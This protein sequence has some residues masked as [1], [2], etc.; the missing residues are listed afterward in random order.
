VKNFVQ[1]KNIL[2]G[3]A[4]V[5]MFMLPAMAQDQQLETVTVTGIR[6]SLASAQAI[7][8]NSDQVVDS[9]TAVDIGA[10]PDR[11]VA[12]ALQ[13]VPG[14]TLVRGDTPNDL[15]RMGSTGNNVFVR[16][17][18]WVQ[19]T[20]NGRNEFSAID[21]RTLAF[22][23][24]SA[25]LLSGVD[26]FKSPTAK[27]I[28]GG[29]GGVID[30]KTRKP[31]DQDGRKFAISGDYTYGDMVDRALPSG[32]ALYS[33]RFNTRIGEIGVLASI[34][35]Q[36]QMSRTSG[37]NLN[38]FDCWTS[39]GTK[40]Q[41]TATDSTYS[42]CVSASDS[43][44]APSGFAWRQ[45]DYRQQRLAANV[46]LQWRP[47]EKL[48]FTLSG[49][50]TFANFNDVEHY[51]YM[52]TSSYATYIA[53][54]NYDS[55]NNWT[56]GSGKLSGI[57]TR[58]GAGHNRTSDISINAKWTP[59][60]NLEISFDS[61]FVESDRQY[62]NNTFATGVRNAQEISLDISDKNSPKISYTDAS[63]S[64]SDPDNYY[65]Y[66]AMDHM[67]YN[68]AH[69]FANRVDAS[70]KFNGEGL[71]G[72]IKSVEVG[73]RAENKYSVQ[74]ATGYNWASI[75][76]MGWGA[77]GVTLAGNF[78][79]SSYTA[80]DGTTVS[81]TS[82]SDN[83]KKLNSYGEL[84]HYNNVF[85]S[86][87]PALYVP[88]KSLVLMNTYAATELTHSLNV[89][90][91]GWNSYT[92]DVGCKSQQVTCLA[93]YENTT[94]GSNVSGN[95]IS[96]QTQDSYAGYA[97]VNF[98]KSTFFGWDIPIDGNFGVRVVQ[99]Q[100]VT[101]TGKVVMPSAPNVA[102]AYSGNDGCTKALGQEMSAGDAT[103]IITNCDD[104]AKAVAFWGDYSN[105]SYSTPRDPVSNHYWNVLPSF[106]LRA[107]L[108][109]TVQARLGYS[110]TMLRPEFKYTA[111]DA[112]Y[113]FNWGGSSTAKAFSFEST[114]SGY[115]YN[116]LLKPMHSTNL[117]A[118]VE[119]YFSQ[120]GSLTASVFGK[121]ISNYIYTQTATESVL[122]P[123]GASMDF[124]NT[125]YVNGTK[126]GVDGW[127]LAYQ[128]FYDFLPG[129]W[130]GFGFQA[131]YTKIFN[132][133]GHNNSGYIGASDAVAS[134]N[135]DLPMEGMSK[136]SYNLALMYAKY[137]IDARLA[138][139]WRS[140][141]MSSSANANAPREPVWLENYGQ[142]D[143]SV[144]YSFWDHYKIGVQVTNITGS[145]FYTDE[146]Y[147]DYHP[148]TNWIAT[149]RKYAIVVRA[150][151]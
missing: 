105:A 8:Q 80:M 9:I 83:V 70:Y 131:N 53:T 148:R 108:S 57:D 76:P 98:A 104:Y 23:D 88:A 124:S 31:F 111:N 142:L 77:S 47:N 29:I 48:E 58:A 107:V 45:L 2:L 22:S 56:G 128:Q 24:V 147:A 52:D 84:F 101:E 146:G 44:M 122:S 10:L 151:W 117:D 46:V 50:N 129:W 67:E 19:T 27:Q 66:W 1:L 12:E 145:E 40:Y 7:K 75:D 94:V 81:A 103:T 30:L 62:L 135:A 110:E 54:A 89:G 132:W 3:G 32:N 136:D 78:T 11:N 138:W 139:N 73:F 86:G 34:D 42:D 90:W 120:S 15:V 134:G 38:T 141:F 102:T 41:A 51:V 95:T 118:S 43:K 116:P 68:S 37:I 20:M 17:L 114:P 16:G 61:Q 123:S 21:G 85:G 36:D 59:T 93:A 26:V 74:R 100:H 121:R 92:Y 71:F 25:D 119:W 143:G 82:I 130:S 6:A 150:N 35:W 149:D 18:S 96:P 69:A 55:K 63:G 79:G 60:D 106:N 112:A 33:D 87:V 127:E 28:E 133:G 72:F 99:T 115:G 126:G 109:S 39:G 13:R 49:F 64:L 113:S 137:D 65:W 97:Q 125:T 4:A 144:F 5:G 140:T 91:G 14:V